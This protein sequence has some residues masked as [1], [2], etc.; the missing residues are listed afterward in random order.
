MSDYIARLMELFLK[1]TG[2]EPVSG[3]NPTFFNNNFA[4]PFT[5]FA[6]DG[7]SV[8]Q[9]FGISI[10]ELLMMERFCRLL[11][12]R[13]ILII[14][15]GFGWSTLGL[16]LM[17]PEASVIAI[18]PHVFIEQTNRIAFL[19]RINS[20]VVRGSSPDDNERI[21]QEYCPI[22]PDLVLID[23]LHTN[24]QIQ[25]D[26]GSVV[27]LCGREAVYFFHDVVIHRMLDGMQRVADLAREKTMSTDIMMGTPSGMAIVYRNELPDEVKA[28]IGVFRPSTGSLQI[29]AKLA[30]SEVPRH[31]VS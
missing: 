21:V 3:L 19:E 27:E 1:H 5:F 25:R 6:R 24:E 17:N 4:V 13:S 18:E 7:E 30:G 26:F 22:R 2:A 29:A 31:K 20:M 14:G 16:A 10:W 15:N 28:V 11:R 9:E 12:P 8:T 23:G